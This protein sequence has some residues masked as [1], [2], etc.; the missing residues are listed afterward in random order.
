M[1]WMLIVQTLGLF[2]LGGALGF[3]GGVFGIG[4]GIIAVPLFVLCMGMDQAHAQGTALVLMVPNLMIAWWRYNKKHQAPV[5][6]AISIAIAGTISTWLTAQIAFR[7]DQRLLHM[8]F[9][10]FLLIVGF[11]QLL[12]KPQTPQSTAPT[13]NPGW[14][15]LLLPLVGALGGSTMGLLGLGGALVATPLLTSVL[16]F[17]Q[18]LA[19]SLSLALVFPCSSIALATYAQAGRVDWLVGI[20]LAIGGLFTVSAGVNLAHRLPEQTM[21]RAFAGLMIAT[22]VWLMLRA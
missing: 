21:R 19:Q 20:P 11:R 14:Q 10:A 22:A 5:R 8:M 4:G 17:S 3:F 12:Q 15:H 2:A 9:N 6:L 13:L 1:D 18:T 16:R 7:V